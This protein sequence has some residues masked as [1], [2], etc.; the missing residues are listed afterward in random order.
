MSHSDCKA[1]N[2]EKLTHAPF[3]RQFARRLGRY[4][5]AAATTWRHV[6]VKEHDPVTKALTFPTLIQFDRCC[7]MMVGSFP[8]FTTALVTGV[9][10]L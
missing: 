4:S 2:S 6:P 9:A 5:I 8:E 7:F 1:R 3:S 10:T